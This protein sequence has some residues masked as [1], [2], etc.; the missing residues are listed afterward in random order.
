MKRTVTIACKLSLMGCSS[1]NLE[2]TKAAAPARWESQGF[3]V[4][5]YEG[6]TWGGWLGGSYGGA[7]VWHRL[8]K[9]PDNGIT[10]S[11]Y[12]QRWGDEFHVYGPHAIDAIRPQ[13]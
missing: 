11:G 2:E 1:S 10:Y 5:D 4:V 13:P 3:T 9:V 8:R 12:V 7:N 6:Y